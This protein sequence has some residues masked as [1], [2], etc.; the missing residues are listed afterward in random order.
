M[1]ISSIFQIILSHPLAKLL[2]TLT[3][4]H[5]SLDI[6]AYPPSS[7]I[8]RDVCVIGGGAAGTYGAV[9]FHDEGRSVVIVESKNALGGHTQTYT[10][11]ITNTSI[12]YGVQAYLNTTLVSSF[13][14]RFDIQLAPLTAADVGTSGRQQYV[15]YTTGKELHGY[16]PGNASVVG[17]VLAAYGA[18]LAKYPALNNGFDLPDPVPEDLLLPFGDFVTKYS[19]Q[20]FPEFIPNILQGLGD[21]LQQSTLHIL[22]YFGPE[23]LQALKTGLVVQANHDN[24]LLYKKA[25][26][27]LGED[28]LLD[29]QIIAMNRECSP[30]KILVQT[31]LGTKLILAKKIV[32]TIPPL[33]SNMAGFD[34]DQNERR[35]FAQ[36]NFTGYY[37][38]VVRNTGIPSDVNLVNLGANTLY[39][40]PVLPAAYAL[41]PTGVTGLQNVKFGS[42]TEL[43]DEEVKDNI[44]A[45]LKRMRTAGTYNTTTPEFVVFSS[46]T[47]FALSV[48][49]EAIKAGFYHDLNT[50]QGQRNTW[51]TGAAFQSLNSALLWRI[52]EELLPTIMA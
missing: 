30:A 27:L 23:I 45:S 8:N 49:A 1:I 34:L 51:Y 6:A 32:I 7:I 38:G 43:P 14:G 47:P 11:P 10:D 26:T 3:T 29:S 52:T 48:S 41:S 21:P 9:R 25:R 36:F 46:H 33:L 18:Q 40:L 13:F 20:A 19:L 42:S 28:V 16:A 35:L 24:S 50:L 44:L 4:T 31:P 15:D 17:K 22:K 5:P 39:N 37:T 2:P 12:N